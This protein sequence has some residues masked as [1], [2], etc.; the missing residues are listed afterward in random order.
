A[1]Q[2]YIDAN[3]NAFSSPATI[4]EVQAAIAAANNTVTSGGT[5]SISGFNCSGALT[6]TLLVGTPATGVTKVITATVATAGTYNISATANGVT[7]SG[8]GTFSG[9]GSQQI[10][11][12]ATGTPTA[13]GTNSFTINTTPSCSFNA[14]TLGNVEYIM[15]S[16]NSATQ[17]LSLDTD[18]AFDSSSVAPGSTIAFNAANSSFTLKAGKTY[19]LTFTGQLNGFSNTTNGV[20]G[21]SW[22]DATTNA[23]LGNSLGEFFPVNNSFW[24]N[25]GSN[26]VDMIY[27]PTTSQNVK[28]RVTNAS[29]TAIFQNKENSVVIQEIG[30]R[31][32]NSVGFTKA[33]YLYVS[34]NTVVNNV[35]SGASLI[36]NTLNESNGIP[37]NTSTGVI[38]LKAGKTYRLTF[39]GSFWYGNPNGYIE[40][41]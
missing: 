37:Y 27:T 11:L 31:G 1:Y 7:F 33:E 41:V 3:P 26:M 15:V 35:N 19:R 24:T 4:A 40:V 9:L 8:S 23:Q 39:N 13:I 32:N 28:L 38:S 14:T 25:S 5:S 29:G 18:L 21:I 30:A 10:T 12:T 16:R 20:V 22:V 34:R 17:T 2:A 6:G 36:Y